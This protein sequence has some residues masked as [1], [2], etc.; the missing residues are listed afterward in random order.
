M[1][2][3]L[4]ETRTVVPLEIR[5]VF[6]FFANPE[7]L[8]LLTPRW[9]R[10]R[11]LTLP[12]WVMQPGTVL[13]YRIRLHGWPIA[14]RTEITVWNPPHQFVDEQRR[15]PYR[16]WIHT[17]DFTETADGTEILDRVE[18]SPRGGALA[19]GLLV[20]SDLRRIFTHRHHALRK[21]L[22]VTDTTARVHVALTRLD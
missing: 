5:Q 10:F 13:D 7:N 3:Y 22:C 9:L 18:Y 1:A 17:H 15:G 19:Q 20:G 16:W 14:W 2:A 6:R 8:N 11:M 4:L 12:P 21:E